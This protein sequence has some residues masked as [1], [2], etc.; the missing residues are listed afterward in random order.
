MAPH[1]GSSKDYG[2]HASSC[3]S[4]LQAQGT[5][6]IKGSSQQPSRPRPATGAALCQECRA[7][8][9]ALRAQRA[10]AHA[11]SVSRRARLFTQAGQAPPRPGRGPGADDGPAGLPAGYQLGTPTGFPQPPSESA[12]RRPSQP[13]CGRL[14]AP[15]SSF[16]RRVRRALPGILG[17]S[18]QSPRRQAY[19]G[20][21]ARGMVGCRPQRRRGRLSPRGR[22]AGARGRSRMPGAQPGL[23]APAAGREAGA[24][25]L[26]RAPPPPS[27]PQ[28]S[29]GP[30]GV[31][32][33]RPEEGRAPRGGRDFGSRTRP[34]RQHTL[35]SAPAPSL[36]PSG[37]P[38]ALSSSLC[39]LPSPLL[40]GPRPAAARSV[41]G[42]AGRAPG[43]ASSA[44]RGDRPGRGGGGR[45]GGS[46]FG[47]TW[48]REGG[49]VRRNSWRVSLRFLS[50][51]V[52]RAGGG[53]A[54]PGD[55]R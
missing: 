48:R 7:P 51:W 26:A 12:S 32:P 31:S 4:P 15:Q 46:L 42:G 33:L 6:G 35:P 17:T 37:P 8:A 45:P 34:A 3:P 22:A 16:Q 14:G 55:P 24:A 25:A 38:G 50:S 1:S 36:P 43:R 27:L 20:A 54:P 11:G 23:T 30:P 39:L 49:V 47:R 40:P 19:R 28:P 44:P 41:Y 53:R 18:A 29:P 13:A 2:S 21:G 10:R 52:P 9:P 5:R